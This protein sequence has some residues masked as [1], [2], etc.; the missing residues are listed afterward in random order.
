MRDKY[1]STFTKDIFSS[2]NKTHNVKHS[3]NYY[4]GTIIVLYQNFL[5]NVNKFG[6]S[7]ALKSQNKD[8]SLQ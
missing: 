7:R 3:H 4:Y 5:G 6:F 8:H 1:T 2:Y